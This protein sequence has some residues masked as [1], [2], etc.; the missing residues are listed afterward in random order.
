MS[1]PS[2]PVPVELLTAATCQEG[3]VSA[4]QCDAWG[5][6]GGMRARLVRTGEWSRL[7]TGVYDV[8]PGVT[9]GLDR[10]R[11]RSAWFG[12]LAYGV[13]AVAVGTSALALHG[14]KGLPLRI[15]PQVALDGTARRPRAGIA[16]RHFDGFATRT[17]GARRIATVESA[18]VQ[19]L[20]D[21]DRDT[22]ISILDAALRARQLDDPGVARVRTALVGRRGCRR[23]EPWWDLVDRRSDSPLE[24]RARLAC[25]DGGIAPDELQVTIKDTHGRFLARG[26]LG[27]RLRGDRWLLAEID[28]REPHSSPAALFEDRERQNRMLASGLVDLRRFTARDVNRPSQMVASLRAAIAAGRR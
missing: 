16:V 3:L 10:Q 26:D 6:T 18:L 27:W 4:A 13:R 1:R 12:M 25:V 2:G 14:V 8:M 23:V 28:G 20:P 11:C 9:L 17:L 7:T 21:L 19:A 22:A 24:T 5:V 15:Q